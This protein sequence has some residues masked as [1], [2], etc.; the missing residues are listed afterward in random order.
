MTVSKNVL[1]G[2]ILDPIESLTPIEKA[3]MAHIDDLVATTE[4]IIA[5]ELGGWAAFTKT[6]NKLATST[7][8]SGRL[9][10]RLQVTKF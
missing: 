10:A 5:D 4:E 1:N 7:A 9:P 2:P 8:E 6:S 3:N